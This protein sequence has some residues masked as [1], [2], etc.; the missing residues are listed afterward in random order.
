M[1]RFCLLVVVLLSCLFSLHAQDTQPT[2]QDM[3]NIAVNCVRANNR[4]D[5]LRYLKEAIR[6]DPTMSDAYALSAA[7]FSEHIVKLLATRPASDIASR[8]TI[9]QLEIGRAHV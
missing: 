7:I 2:A 8:D 5:A 4:V 1:K 9:A 6:L 3:Y